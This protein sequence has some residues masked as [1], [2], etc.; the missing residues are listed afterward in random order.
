MNVDIHTCSS[1]QFTILK[2]YISQFELDDRSLDHTQFLVAVQNNK[3]LGFGRIR[4]HKDCSELCSLGVIEPERN[5]GIGR[6]LTKALIKKAKQPLYL[7]CIIPGFFE[8]LGFSVCHNYPAEL[9]EKL[10]YCTNELVVPE[11]YV[12]MQKLNS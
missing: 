6:A 10:D 4:E 2:N 1:A 7:V 11:T 12:V 3:V 5:K 9:Q 8:P